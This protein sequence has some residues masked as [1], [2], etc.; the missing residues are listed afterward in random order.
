MDPVILSRWQ[1]AI[2][3]IYHFLFIPITLGTSLY[4]AV[5]ETRYVIS[6]DELYKSMVKFWSKIFL[7]NFAIGVVTGIVQEFHFGFNW[8]E[9]SRFVG[10]VIGVPIALD[11][12][13]AFFLESTFIGI[14][15]FG[16]DKL[17]KKAHAVT[18]WLVAIGAHISAFWIL[19]ANSFMHNP[20]GFTLRNGR[21]EMIDF[22][23][24]VKNPYVWHQYPHVVTA[25]FT[26]AGFLYMSFSAWHL[27][28]NKAKSREF[29]LR[30]F[31]L[32]ATFALVGS[33]LVGLIGHAQGQFL[34]KIQPLKVMAMEGHWETEQPGSFTVIAGIDQKNQENP[35]EIRIPYMLSLL[36]YNDFSSE[37]PGLIDLQAEAEAQYGPGNYI[38]QVALSFWSLRVMIGF[39]LLMILISGLAVFWSRNNTIEKRSWFLKVLIYTGLLPTIASIAGWIIAETGRYPWIVRGLQKIKD[40]VSPNITTGNILFSLVTLTLL[41]AVLIVVGVSLALKYGTSDPVLTEEKGE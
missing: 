36:L 27:L 4:L 11:S 13:L 10:D 37:V 28:Q 38:P 32:A 23:A 30:S 22:G 39:G 33:V 29:F 25:G 16:W 14:W 41:Y 24:I 7:I 2:T 17:S 1:F 15:I 18:I 5:L 40:A 26:I 35:W 34:A 19:A 8:S 21:A 12:L 3:T 6:G 31:K 20:V 9:Y